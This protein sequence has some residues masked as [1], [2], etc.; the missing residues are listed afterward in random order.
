MS[1]DVLRHYKS[2]VRFL[3]GACAVGSSF[4]KVTSDKVGWLRRK[5]SLARFHSKS[6][7]R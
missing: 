5:V 6:L 7:S 3:L 1:L 4:F 2:G